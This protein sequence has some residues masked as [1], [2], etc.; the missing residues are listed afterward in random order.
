MRFDIWHYPP[1]TNQYNSL[2]KLI[3]I[4]YKFKLS[5]LLYSP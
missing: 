5:A 3:A 4:Y 1:E 2:L